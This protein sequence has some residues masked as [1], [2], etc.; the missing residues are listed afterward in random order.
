M[1][2]SLLLV[3]AFICSSVASAQTND[4]SVNETIQKIKN[5][6]KIIEIRA[7]NLKAG[8]RNEFQKLFIEQS[9]PLLKKWKVEVVAYGPSLHDEDT[10]FLFRAYKNLQDRQQ[11]E[12]AFYGSDDWKKGPRE[13]ILSLILNYTT[14]VVPTDSENTLSIKI[15]DMTNEQIKKEESAQLSNLNAQFIK[16]FLHQDTVAHN[17]I[18]HKDFVCIENTGSIVQRDEYMKHWATDFNNSGYASFGYKEEFIRIFGNM[19]L[20]RAK[21]VYTKM[22]NGKETKGNSIYTD[23]YVKE[24][25]K[26]QCVQAQIT[27]LK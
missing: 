18:I 12:D 8:T 16:N 13:A 5:P 27:P 14:I 10:W 23:T 4:N 22:V 20:V 1:I 26:W 11:S 6:N 2:K 3:I 7:Y 17:E 9:L 21:T 19:A 24:N 15:N 25:G